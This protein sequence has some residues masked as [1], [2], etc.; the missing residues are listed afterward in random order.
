MSETPTQHNAKIIGE[1]RAHQGRVGGTWEEIPLLLLHHTGEKS[2]VSPVNPVAYLPHDP[3]YLIW[4]ANGGAPNN[5]DWYY[6]LNAQP[7]TRMR[8]APRRSTS[9][10]RRRQA[11]SV[12]ASSQVQP[13][14][15]PQLAEAA[16]KTDRVIPMIVLTPRGRA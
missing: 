4:A 8:S 7:D 13:D 6:N 9:W 15:T 5:P 16:R 3:G 14:A 11:R 12:S 2:G 10:P 1:F